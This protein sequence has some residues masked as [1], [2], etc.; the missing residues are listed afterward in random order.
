MAL[1]YK[2]KTRFL[3][4]IFVA[5]TGTTYGAWQVGLQEGIMA[6]AHDS[7]ELVHIDAAHVCGETVWLHLR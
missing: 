5:I 4:A 2:T 3:E 1:I 7:G 6:I